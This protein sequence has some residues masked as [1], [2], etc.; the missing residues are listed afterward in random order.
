VCETGG[1]CPFGKSGVD[2][3]LLHSSLAPAGFVFRFYF[4]KTT[5]STTWKVQAGTGGCTSV[6]CKT[7]VVGQGVIPW[8]MGDW[9][10]LR[11]AARR[12]GSGKTR[13]SWSAEPVGRM[14]GGLSVVNGSVD[15]DTFADARGSLAMGSGF[16][17]PMSQ[18]DNL[19]I[20]PL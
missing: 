12:L 18:W 3:A 10:R 4:G 5:G 14:A 16:D 7:A 9:M 15:V 8:A 20:S 11:L 1:C 19:T 2:Q 17:C 6:H 13:V